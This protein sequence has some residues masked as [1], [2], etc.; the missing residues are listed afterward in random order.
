MKAWGSKR[1]FRSE[2]MDPDLKSITMDR[3]TGPSIQRPNQRLQPKPTQP[4]PAPPPAPHPVLE[5]VPEPAAPEPV[6]DLSAEHAARVQAEMEAAHAQGY[7][8]GYEA[9]SG[10]GYAAGE[11]SGREAGLAAGQE[12]GLMAGRAQA[13]EELERIQ[14]MMEELQEQMA[15]YEA[16]MA[17]PILDVA[18]A[19]AQQVVRGEIKADPARLLGVIREALSALPELHQQPRVQL[20][21]EDCVLVQTLMKEQAATDGWR[22]EADATIEP[23]GC[24]LQTGS[25]DVDMTL[26]TRWRRVVATLG[27]DDAWS[28][29]PDGPG[30]AD[31]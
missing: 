2:E 27:R 24:K 6:I 13:S 11:R 15:A 22:F 20:H 23:G 9:G 31:T 10:E 4:P 3:F 14:S 19:V 26:P 21:P 25:V 16:E 7:Q 30:V 1:I 17:Q 5:P 29:D 28:D 18:L 12:E 8:A